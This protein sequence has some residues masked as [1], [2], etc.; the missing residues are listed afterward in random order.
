[1]QSYMTGIKRALEQPNDA[2][3]SHEVFVDFKT[4]FHSAPMNTV[5]LTLRRGASDEAW[6]SFRL[7]LKLLVL[8]WGITLLS[9]YRRSSG[10]DLLNLSNSKAHKVRRC[11]SV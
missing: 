10:K 1:M 7:F 4:A 3:L 5:M 2:A 11:C 9:L 6:Q 8:F